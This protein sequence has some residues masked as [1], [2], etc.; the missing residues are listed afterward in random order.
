MKKK[1]N[2]PLVIVIKKT[3][4]LCVSFILH[5][6]SAN[7]KRLLQLSDDD[8]LKHIRLSTDWKFFLPLNQS[9]SISH[10][11][12]MLPIYSLASSDVLF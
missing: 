10:S 7:E 12:F 9:S 6:T 8:S 5:G 2:F 3:T 11:F 4:N 1:K